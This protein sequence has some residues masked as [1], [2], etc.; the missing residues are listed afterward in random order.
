MLSVV[1]S[2]QKRSR[3]AVFASGSVTGRFLVPLLLLFGFVVLRCL[4]ERRRILG[5]R[6]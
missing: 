1:R 4:Y 2:G 5:R 6:G 3:T